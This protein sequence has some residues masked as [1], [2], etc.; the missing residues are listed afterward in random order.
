[1]S[2]ADSYGSF[3]RKALHDDQVEE[4]VERDDGLLLKSRLTKTYFSEIEDWNPVER[5]IIDH[6]RSRVLDLACGPGRVSLYLQRKGIDVMGVDASPGAVEVAKKRGVRA[7]ATVPLEEV[8]AV[9]GPFETAT[10]FGNDFGL[11]RD[12]EHAKMILSKIAAVTSDSAHLLAIACDPYQTQAPQ[13]LRYHQWN[14]ERGR[15]PGQL[16]IRVIAKDVVGEWFDYLFLSPEE[17][18]H[19]LADTQWRMLRLFTHPSTVSYGAMMG[20]RDV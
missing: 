10:L 14:R 12:T 9:S 16:R 8:D 2:G 1:M 3:Y 19:I 7:V 11:L 17:M 5:E 4:Y 6:A 20:K 15:L 18:E 13:H